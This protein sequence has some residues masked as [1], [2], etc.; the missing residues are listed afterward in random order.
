MRLIHYSAD[1]ILCSGGALEAADRMVPASTVAALAGQNLCALTQKQID[2]AARRAKIRDQTIWESE[3]DTIV[4]TC[5]AREIVLSLP[6][7]ATINSSIDRRDP[8][9][10]A[11]LRLFERV[12]DHAFGSD[13]RLDDAAGT[14]LVPYLR[15]GR[16]AAVLSP[17]AFENYTGPQRNPLPAELLERDTLPIEI[18]QPVPYPML[19]ATV[20]V[21]GDVRLRLRVGATGHVSDVEVLKSIPLLDKAA[22]EAARSWKFKAQALS[23]D[24][25]DV[26]LRFQHRCGG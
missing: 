12:R 9:V 24:Q 4:A 21:A 6:V 16:F 25:V 26:T 10:A 2:T 23:R 8:R 14:A 19:A 17:H 18:Y 5:G 11:A 1:Y 3:S 7:R 13:I 15:S 20:R 22:I